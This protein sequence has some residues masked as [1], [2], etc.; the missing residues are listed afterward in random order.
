M[1]CFFGAMPRTIG[2]GNIW[3]MY[4]RRSPTIGDSYD[5]CEQN[6]HSPGT[7]GDAFR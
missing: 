7:V 5:E 4:P 3:K 1:T 2:F 6:I